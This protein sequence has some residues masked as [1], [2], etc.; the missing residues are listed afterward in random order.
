MRDVVGVV[1]EGLQI[2][3]FGNGAIGPSF[4]D[5]SEKDMLPAHRR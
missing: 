3:C 2:S 4:G 1:G 5:F